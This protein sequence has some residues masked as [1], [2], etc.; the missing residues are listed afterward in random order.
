MTQR[1][2]VSSQMMQANVQNAWSDNSYRITANTIQNLGKDIFDYNKQ[3]EAIAFQRLDLEAQ[4][5][6]NEQ[7]EQ[8]KIADSQEKITQI[9]ADFNKNLHETFGKNKW[10]KKWLEAR[11]QNFIAANSIDVQKL[12]T[13]KKEEFTLLETDKT[14]NAYA[15][16]IS[17]SNPDKANALV[18]QAHLMIDNLSLTPTKKYDLKTGF[19]KKWVSAMVDNNTD[20]AI[21]LLSDNGKLSDISQIERQDYLQK[22]NTLKIAK[23]KE[24]LSLKNL[25]EKQNKLTNDRKISE[26]KVGLLTS[27]YTIKDIEQAKID[28]VFDLSPKEYYNSYAIISKKGEDKNKN[29]S[30]PEVLKTLKQGIIDNVI[31]EDDIVNARLKDE[32]SASDAK[33]FLSLLKTKNENKKDSSDNLRN[34]INLIGNGKIQSFNDLTTYYTDNDIDYETFNKAWSYL[35]ETNNNAANKKKELETLN[36]EESFKAITKMIDNN[37]ITSVD[38]INDLYQNSKIARKTWNDAVSYMEKRDEKVKSRK[39]EL[40]TLNEEESFK[41]ITE[42]IDKNEITSVDEINDLYHAKE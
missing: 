20:M 29:I 17:L 39:K 37:E 38:E 40:E 34:I 11:G 23:Q 16:E 2:L 19:T 35:K 3:N 7:L 4:K 15:D 9:E 1:N 25:E 6:Q 12:S 5:L 36:E 18:N 21:N 8:I 10:G 42:M 26:L 33:E 32:I 27:K 30:N 28:G 24:A 22:A 31:G 41:A 13:I 14:L